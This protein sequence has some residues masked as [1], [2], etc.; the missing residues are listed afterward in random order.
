MPAD[1]EA[2]ATLPLLQLAV[3][4][5]VQ[6]APTTLLRFK[7]GKEE[8]LDAAIRL[9]KMPFSSHPLVFIVA[10]CSFFFSSRLTSSKWGF[11]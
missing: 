11:E 5:L 6:L 10:L 9:D 8:S 3:T 2:A 7:P 4:F 1:K